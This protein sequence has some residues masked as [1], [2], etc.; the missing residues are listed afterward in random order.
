MVRLN[1]W[2]LFGLRT[3]IV[4]VVLNLVFILLIG[5]SVS[6]YLSNAVSAAP[7]V[8]RD[9]VAGLTSSSITHLLIFALVMLVGSVSYWLAV[10]FM[11]EKITRRYTKKYGE[12]ADLVING[13]ILSAVFILISMVGKV[14]IDAALIVMA[15]GMVVGFIT[16]WV[17]LNIVFPIFPAPASSPQPCVP[18][19]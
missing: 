11:R 3:G 17:C 12:L 16:V 9:S 19:V 7:E 2:A 8:V 5:G 6:E 14:S 15:T 4:F 13:T 1:K 10:G 18:S